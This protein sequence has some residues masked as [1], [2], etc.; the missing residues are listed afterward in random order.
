VVGTLL[1]ER[2]LFG[3]SPLTFRRLLAAAVGLLGVWLLF[4]SL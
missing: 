1:G 2:V 3:L 4:R